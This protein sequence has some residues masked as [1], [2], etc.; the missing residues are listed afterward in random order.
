MRKLLGVA[1]IV[2]ASAAFF[3]ACSH[4]VTSPAISGNRADPD[5]ACN[6]KPVSRDVSTITLHG[7]NM[8]PMP[9][10]SMEG[11]EQLLLPT[12]QLTVVDPIGAAAPPAGPITVAD[13]PTA[14]ATSHVKWTS[15]QT[16]SF[17]IRPEDKLPA[18]V[19]SITVTNPD[20][21]AKTTIEKGLAV[22]PPPTIAELKPPAICDDQ[23]DQT[24]VVNGTNFL[25]FDDKTPSV[26][27]G[28]GASAKT[29]PATN[30]Q[31]CTPVNGNLVE[32]NVQLCKS[33]TIK[34]PKGDFPVTTATKFPVTLTNPAPAD[35]QS[36]ETIEITI[37]P[38]P[39]VDSVAPATVCEGGS[40]ITV[41]G[42]NFMSG[43]K[44]TLDC[45]G[46]KVDAGTVTV[47]TDGKQLSATF[48]G[49]ATPGTSCDVI[50]KNPDGCEDRPLPHK[51]VT[52]VAGPIVFYVDPP[53]VYNGINTRI[54]IFVTSITPP[55][56]ANAV[57][58]VPTGTTGPVTNLAFTTVPT[59]PNRLQAVIPISQAPGVYD[60]TVKDS[61]ACFATLPKAVTVTGSLSVSIK[62]VVPPFGWTGEDTSITVFRDTAAAAPLDKPFVDSPR[63]FLNPATAAATDVAVPIVGVSFFDKDR[64][65][66]LVPKGTAVKKYDLVLVNPDGTVGLLKGAYD[67]LTDAPPVVLS[68]TPSSIPASSGQV[69][70]LTG[71]NFAAGDKVTLECVNAAGGAVAAPAVTSAAPACAAGA[72]T[73]SITIDGSTLAAGDV[74]VVRVTNPDGAFGEFSA[75]GV[76]TPSLNLNSPKVGSVMNVGRRALSAASGDATTAARFV[77]A[78]GGD[79]GTAAG[80]LDSYEFAPV[81]LFGKMG[82][83]TVS[84]VKLKAKRTL[85]G[86]ATVGRYIYNVGGDDGAGPV[87]SAER[88]LILSPRE[89]PEI[90]DVDLALGAKGLDAGDYHYRVSATFAATDTDN[91]GGESL[92]SDEFSLRIPA[93]P[94]KK[95]AVTV[96]FR[97][98]LDSLGAPIAGVSGYRI[99]RTAKANDPSGSEVLLG[100]V[101]GAATLTFVD[102]GTATPGTAKPLPFGST[103]EWLTLPAMATKRAGAGVAA[104]FDP[105]TAGQFYVYALMGK[106][107]AT[108]ATG[109]YE[110]LKVN[111]AANG[112]QT[113]G[114]AW[115]PGANPNA[116]PRWQFGAWVATHQTSTLVAAADSWIY[117][118]GGMLP[119]GTLT[120]AV[121]A[122]KVAAGG[123]LGT[124]DA[125]PKDFSST[126]AGYGICAANDQLFVFGGQG[127]APSSGAK[128]AKLQTPLPSLI[129]SSWN[130]EGLSMTHGR[131]LLGSSVQSAFIFLLG[132]QTDEPSAASKTTELVIW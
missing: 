116:T 122:G 53:V 11:P 113:F 62:S 35:C 118:G 76:T 46:T 127:A 119:G 86:A 6:G 95:V 4:E 83:W 98:P 30:P 41:N 93:F 18:G 29:Y 33:V 78:I 42:A 16:M 25:F 94:S 47:A 50:V 125:T 55:L 102:D 58:M 8:T 104:A 49:G 92:A 84:P 124:W 89:T 37:E 109:S 63:L 36:S 79:N 70:V 48:G 12:V 43:A 73:Q 21:K 110:F 68:A 74:C 130:S 14:P 67:E 75:I 108:T 26:V 131:Y 115:T 59:F 90:T 51:K 3:S 97:A 123:D 77:Y 105:A 20:G 88:A 121:D 100:T 71:R 106:D 24:V 13:D 99:Y 126:S 82:A 34:I 64:V 112:R 10:K 60:L 87:S 111:I 120:G 45:G 117:A 39:R 103:G 22:V 57:T 44:V 52:V 66:G 28:T 9:S 128:S 72:C 61:S 17:D 80:A 132:G 7:E 23:A 85:A 129:P 1:L 65:T 2:G 101:T 5:L 38:P 69:V 91:P 32:K 40:Q 114:T 107:T 54:T 31:D 56:P 96:V 19:M 27:I 15:E 81:D